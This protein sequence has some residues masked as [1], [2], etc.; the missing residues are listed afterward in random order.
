[1]RT[2]IIVC[3]HNNRCLR[4]GRERG[5][6]IMTFRHSWMSGDAECEESG[7]QWSG[8]LL[9]TDSFLSKMTPSTQQKEHTNTNSSHSQ[10]DIDSWLIMW[11]K[12][13]R[14]D[15][16]GSVDG[17]APVV[18]LQVG[19]ALAANRYTWDPCK[20]YSMRSTL[21]HNPKVYYMMILLFL[22]IISSITWWR[23][24]NKNHTSN[25]FY[26]LSLY[27]HPYFIKWHQQ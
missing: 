11:I 3:L 26:S 10:L 25:N 24:F 7:I 8:W 22:S 21:K 4:G 16:H 13:S 9:R 19:N 6:T 5:L 17:V 1:M 23:I 27:L 12:K 18:S 15:S 14:R 2:I 20:T